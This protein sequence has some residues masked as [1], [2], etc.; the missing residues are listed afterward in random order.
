[1]TLENRKARYKLFLENNKEAA[2]AL[3]EKYPDVVEVKDK[4]KKK[5]DK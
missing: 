1:M 4:P 2:E 3:A 5:E